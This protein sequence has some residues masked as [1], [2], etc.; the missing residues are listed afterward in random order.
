MLNILTSQMR[1]LARNRIGYALFSG[2]KAAFTSF[3]RTFYVLWLQT[4]G[5]V[6]AAFSITGGVAAFRLYRAH[7]LVADPR[8]FW[9]TLIFT[10]VCFWF[11]VT[12]F[13]KA[14]LR[15]Q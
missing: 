8:R 5:L 2:A 14:K 13:W 11:T 4:T 12:S 10:T 9:I 3:A 15:S 6:F 1:A 7:A